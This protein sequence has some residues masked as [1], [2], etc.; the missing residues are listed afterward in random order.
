MKKRAPL[1]ER[2]AR[3]RMWVAMRTL[4]RFTTADL[5]A[6]AEVGDGHARKYVRAL[7]RAE[8]LR[9]VK[10]TASGRAAGHAIYSLVRDTGPHAPRAGKAGL[11]DPNI[12]PARPEPGQEPVMV[13]R[14]DYDRALACVRAC[15][16]MAD[17]EQDVAA[18]RSG[19]VG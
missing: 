3:T 2:Q 4:R 1:Q 8:Y 16:G 13:P 7:V 10:P 12:E 9:C 17:P 18:L 14:A 6:T 15:A 5:Q 11:L 19:A